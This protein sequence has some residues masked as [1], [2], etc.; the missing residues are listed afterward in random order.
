MFASIN[1]GMGKRIKLVL[2]LLQLFFKV[3]GSTHRM[4][5]AITYHTFIGVILL[6]T[7]SVALAD[8]LTNLI[9]NSNLVESSIIAQ[10]D[11]PIDNKIKQIFLESSPIS[12]GIIAARLWPSSVY[13]RLTLEAANNIDTKHSIDA[14]T[15]RLTI[16]ISNTELN[17]I[18]K[19]LNTKVLAID[20]LI[21]KIK[22][23]QFGSESVRVIIYL[24]QQVQVQTKII[25]PVKLG[26]VDYKYRYVFDIYPEQNVANN[27]LS[28]DLLAL[29]Q[30][31]NDPIA[32]AEENPKIITTIPEIAIKAPQY[33]EL[34]T[35]PVKAKYTGRKLVVMLD[36]GHGGEDPGAIGAGGTREKNVVLG[37]AKALQKLINQSSHMEAHLTRDQDIFIPLGT[38]V[39][40]AR[41]KKADLFIS[42]HADAV[43]N[44]S[45][46]G[47]SVYTLSK[48]G[49]SSSFAK[50]LAKSQNNADLIGGMSFKTKDKMVNR[51]L[52]D[53][54]QTWTMKTSSKLGQ[55]LLSHMGG[56]NRLHKKHVEHAAFAVLK[57]PDIPSALVETAFI[58]NPEEEAMLTNVGSQQKIAQALFSSIEK[59]AKK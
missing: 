34:K 28:D 11:A 39:K 23:S 22:V 8:E 5:V 4:I 50:W 9:A 51:V 12:G 16:E 40:I 48:R 49:A 29:L 55:M 45:A 44:R 17:N 59:F 43:D 19:D 35:P 7:S 37:I 6:A 18:L 52:L 38:R 47:S 27:D 2:N 42:I 26:S 20:P 10:N 31:K 21:D 13:T 14:K 56:V 57:A 1:G 32:T 15:S 33:S 41:I 24:K 58:S 54:A 25:P 3:V 53:M 36:P 46:R 30:F